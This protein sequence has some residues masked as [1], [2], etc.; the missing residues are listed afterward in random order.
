MA[1]AQA[2]LEE[3]LEAAAD[4]HQR[5]EVSLKLAELAH[6]RDH[7]SSLA[8]F[9]SVL[10]HAGDDDRLRV[11]A[12]RWLAGGFG[13]T[14]GPDEGLVYAEQAIRVAE[15]LG[16]PLVLARALLALAQARYFLTGEILTERYERAA[17]LAESAG[18]EDVA[19]QAASEY[20]DVLMDSWEFDR[21]RDI[22]ERLRLPAPCQGGLP[23]DKRAARADIR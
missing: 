21:A 17:A 1:R 14:I 6:E 18:D 5:A 4:D 20:A 7:A 11:D 19:S 13:T 10:E 2:L 12:L 9:R 23:G 22:F 16:D 8:L 3:A 15:R